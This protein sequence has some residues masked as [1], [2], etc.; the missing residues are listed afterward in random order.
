[1]PKRIFNNAVKLLLELTIPT[2]KITTGMLNSITII[3][4][5]VKFLL[6]NKFIADEI[7]PMHDSIKD[8][9]KKLM[10]SE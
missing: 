10:S 1:M 2:E 8:P 4:P 6:F 5:S 7:D 3:L 9:I